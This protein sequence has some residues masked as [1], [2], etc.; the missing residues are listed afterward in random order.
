MR[1]GKEEALTEILRRS[2]QIACRRSRQQCRALFG[3]AGVLL[4]ALAA[5]IA[6]VPGQGALLQE[7]SVYG[8]F[9]LSAEAGG[10]VLSAVVA[11]LLGIVVTL[12]SLRMQ[13]ANREKNSMETS[14]KEERNL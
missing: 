13:R 14:D 2:E 5:V 9:L 7:G 12:L 4:A 11:F 10:Y 6:F 3:A 1:Y 8:A